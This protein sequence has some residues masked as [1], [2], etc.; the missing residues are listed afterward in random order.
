[1]AINGGGNVAGNAMQSLQ[2]RAGYYNLLSQAAGI[3]AKTNIEN[4]GMQTDT[5]LLGANDK[6]AQF[7]A[8]Q[9]KNDNA[10]GTA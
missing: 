4:K 8:Q 5:E 10:L 7:Y 3:E 9:S 6:I 1:M 2:R